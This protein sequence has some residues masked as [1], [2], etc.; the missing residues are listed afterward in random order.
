MRIA[1][2]ATG[3]LAGAPAL[4]LLASLLLRRPIFS[5]G[6]SRLTMT[7]KGCEVAAG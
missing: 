1:A 6:E 4:E 5:A 2:R 3:C 7:V